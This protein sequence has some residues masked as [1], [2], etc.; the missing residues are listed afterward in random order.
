MIW[1]M[2]L[3][4]D[5]QTME[6]ECP[7]AQVLPLDV[8]Q[9]SH[10]GPSPSE[11]M[12]WLGDGTVEG[13]LTDYA[14]SDGANP[15]S[16]VPTSLRVEIGDW[17]DWTESQAGSCGGGDAAEDWS[18]SGSAHLV[19]TASGGA[20]AIDEVRRFT[21]GYVP[22]QGDEGPFYGFSFR[23]DTVFSDALTAAMSVDG[24]PIDAIGTVYTAVSSD[25]AARQV[26]FVLDPTDDADVERM[27]G[28]QATWTPAI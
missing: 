27:R 12:G 3:A 21:V 8:D 14:R 15:T 5:Q 1:M 11:V 26:Q 24:E 7:P 17:S 13:S 9:P 28:L 20:F 23:W 2:M 22:A 16:G 18:M 10:L 6:Y 25:G 19:A 4:C